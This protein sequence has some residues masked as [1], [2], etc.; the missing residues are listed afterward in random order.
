MSIDALLRMQVRPLLE[1]NEHQRR[2]QD[3]TGNLRGLWHESSRVNARKGPNLGSSLNA[4]P[5]VGLCMQPKNWPQ[6]L[7]DVMKSADSQQWWLLRL[8]HLQDTT[9]HQAL[10][11]PV[12]SRCL[13]YCSIVRELQAEGPS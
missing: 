4:V 10:S 11:H 6:W 8:V 2:A 3:V 7:P 9:V 1:S 12:A 13:W 5:E